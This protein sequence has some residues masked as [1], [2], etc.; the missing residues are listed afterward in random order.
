MRDMAKR[1]S[2]DREAGALWSFSLEVYAQPE[3]E[4][5][6][7]LMQEKLG[8]DINLLL[9]CL[10]LGS[11]GRGRLNE[12]ELIDL[13]QQVAFWQR[14]IIQPLRQVRRRLKELSRFGGE[15]FVTMRKSVSGCELD[16]EAVEQQ[17]LEQALGHRHPDVELGQVKRLSDALHN[18]LL[19]MQRTDGMEPGWLRSMAILLGACFPTTTR[20]QILDI[21]QAQVA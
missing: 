12:A 16:A 13:E 18:L 19:L 6:C 1:K 4:Q 11:S 20:E 10:W 7:L 17:M 5:A 15:R 2:Q 21:L 8:V 14:E 3:V 9:V